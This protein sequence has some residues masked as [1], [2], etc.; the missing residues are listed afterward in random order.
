MY[1]RNNTGKYILQSFDT[2]E[3]YA[4][5]RKSAWEWNQRESEG[6]HLE[7]QGIAD[8]ELGNVNRTRRQEKKK[9]RDAAKALLNAKLNALEPILDPEQLEKA[10]GTIKNID[11]QLEWHCKFDP[12]ILKKITLKRK[13]EKLEALIDAVKR[14]NNGEVEVP[15]DSEDLDESEKESSGGD[16]DG[17]GEDPD[18]N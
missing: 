3:K 9:K 2:S 18:L 17:D 6:K 11:L 14:I 8:Q 1:A 16:G 5:L 13:A 4:F 15:E 10:L 7:K 12:N